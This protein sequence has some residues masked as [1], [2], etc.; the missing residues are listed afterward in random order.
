L[1]IIGFFWAIYKRQ[2]IPVL[3]ILLTTILGGFL[4]IGAPSSSHYVVAIPAI[5]WLIAIPLSWLMEHGQ[6]RLALAML[7][8]VVVTDLGFYFGVYVPSHPR[9]LIGSFPP[10]F[11]P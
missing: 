1:F 7:F 3:W 10:G 8:A 4:S 5:C 2:F 9:D 6:G 11:P